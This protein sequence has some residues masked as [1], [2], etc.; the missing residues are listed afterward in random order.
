MSPP[1]VAESVRLDGRRAVVTGA[2][3]GIGLVTATELARAGASVVLACRNESKA[4]A[5]VARIHESVPDARV[6]LLALDLA[7][8]ES[9]RAAGAALL[10]GPPIDLLVCNAGLAGAKGETQ[11]GFE[12]TFGVNHLGHFALVQAVKGHV[13]D[14]GRIVVVASRAHT[15]A[16]ALDLDACT[17][18][19]RSATGFPEYAVSKL[20]NVLFAR[21][22]SAELAGRRI[23][24]ASLHPGVVA[25]DI[26]RKIPWPFRGLAKL[27]MLTNAEGA[28]TSLHCATAPDIV[29]NTGKYW[30]SC[31]ERAPSALALDDA[32]AD[33]LWRRSEEWT[34]LD[35]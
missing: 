19:T 24:V 28:R 22:L 12:L 21:R 27:F 8:L 11:D 9:V 32:L 17:K 23:A 10:Q 16:K 6:E 30:D 34:Q 18:P 35:P 7:S 31:R 4:E 15:R 3:T 33:E 26:W 1:L 14:G 25:S 2:N 20:A 5:A 29:E 13:V